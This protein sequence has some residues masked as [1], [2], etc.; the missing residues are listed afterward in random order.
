MVLSTMHL[1][2]TMETEQTSADGCM[3]EDMLEVPVSSLEINHIV[4]ETGD[5]STVEYM[6]T[7]ETAVEVNIIRKMQIVN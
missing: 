4:T 1:P 2:V 5:A 7:P 3:Q 6:E